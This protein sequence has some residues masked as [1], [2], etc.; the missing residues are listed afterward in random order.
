MN[1]RATTPTPFLPDQTTTPRTAVL[2]RA[3]AL[4][5]P[6]DIWNRC[7]QHISACG[8]DLVVLPESPTQ[9]DLDRTSRRLRDT[10]HVIIYACP[11]PNV[12]LA[13]RAVR[14]AAGPSALAGLDDL[15]D[16]SR[17]R[18]LCARA[19]I[20][21]ADGIT[22]LGPAITEAAL[23][24]LHHHGKVVVKAPDGWA[25]ENIVITDDP[26]DV[27]HALRAPGRHLVEAFIDGQ[28]F[29][30][31]LVAAHGQV[32]F[33]GWVAG[34][35]TTSTEHPIF[36]T[37]Y[38][39]AANV[40][41]ALREPC[42]RLIR[43]SGYQG[44]ANVNLVVSGGE[45][46]IL[47]CNP[48]TSGMTNLL[49]FGNHPCALCLAVSLQTGHSYRPPRPVPAVEIAVRPDTD[50]TRVNPSHAHYHH[51]DKRF[52]PRVFLW[53]HDVHDA[54]ELVSP[55]A[56][57]ELEPLREAAGEVVG[58]GPG[59][60]DSRIVTEARDLPPAA[61]VRTAPPGRPGSRSEPAS[62]G[63]FDACLEAAAGAQAF[64]DGGHVTTDGARGH[65]EALAR[66]SV[67]EAPAEEPQKFAFGVGETRLRVLGADG[68]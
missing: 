20:R 33:T 3:D 29:S 18:D 30:V 51:L 11:D 21:T 60:A 40:P 25:G 62:L 55:T 8:A 61:P 43:A 24:L 1:L 65:P 2:M 38:S 67:S 23:A 64:H 12:R 50:H 58:G 54:L 4:R 14:T 26:A 53:G 39:P 63:G 17:T 59:H 13:A 45:T 22:G 37:R 68:A 31:E 41:T 57:R 48:R 36:R 5:L 44:I 27:R 15:L 9:E 66:G 32:V 52:P 10:Q 56:A 46:Y 16:K 28:E 6:T 47:E 34:G 49:A 42:E 35:S 19:G 7:R